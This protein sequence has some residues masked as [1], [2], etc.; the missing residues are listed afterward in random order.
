MR[1]TSAPL[2][3]ARRTSSSAAATLASR[4]VE[5]DICVMAKVTRRGAI[6]LCFDWNLVS[7]D[8]VLLF[9]PAALASWVISESE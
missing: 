8:L 7:Q 9:W 2:A 5:Q 6:V 1:M 3:A 4:S